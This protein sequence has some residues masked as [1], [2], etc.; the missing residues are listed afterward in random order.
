MIPDIIKWRIFTVSHTE[1]TSF[2][3]FQYIV[4]VEFNTQAE[5]LHRMMVEGFLDESLL[6]Q[7]WERFCNKLKT[8]IVHSDEK[9][10]LKHRMK[11]ISYDGRSTSSS[12][13][14]ARILYRAFFSVFCIT[15]RYIVPYKSGNSDFSLFA[16]RPQL[17]LL[18]RW[19][20]LSPG[21]EEESIY[22]KNKLLMFLT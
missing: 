2:F 11:L 1:F 13:A 3:R 18:A 22:H 6:S 15:P 16:C 10:G 12:S 4:F 9:L 8:L 5:T 20:Q 17:G 21:P 19:L 14:F 7:E